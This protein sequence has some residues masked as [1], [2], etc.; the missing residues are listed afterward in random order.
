[1]NISISGLSLSTILTDGEVHT[2]SFTASFLVQV[3]FGGGVVPDERVLLFTFDASENYRLDN[4]YVGIGYQKLV[5]AKFYS[6]FDLTITRQENF[7]E[8]TDY[9]YITSLGMTLGYRL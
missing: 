3:S 4:Q 8:Q 2:T 1:M 5:S 6:R 7:S 9:L